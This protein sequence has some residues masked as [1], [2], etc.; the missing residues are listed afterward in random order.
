MTSEDGASWASD[1]ADC[2]AELLDDLGSQ[3]IFQSY[4]L[5]PSLRAQYWPA[6][7][8]FQSQPFGAWAP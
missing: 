3:I 1:D 8:R 4:I 5:F 2:L 7:P 6:G